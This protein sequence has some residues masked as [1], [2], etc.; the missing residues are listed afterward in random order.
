MPKASGEF[1]V[2]LDVGVGELEPDFVQGRI[3]RESGPVELEGVVE[4]KIGAGHL[5]M[6]NP[7]RPDVFPR[8]G[9]S[10]VNR[11]EKVFF[12]LSW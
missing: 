4:I 9:L 2:D 7:A 11:N 6:I 5:G 1:G 3:G 10:W 12:S 8:R